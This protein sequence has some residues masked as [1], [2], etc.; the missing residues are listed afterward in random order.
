M[1]LVSKDTI[2]VGSLC[3]RANSDGTHDFAG[4]T[5]LQAPFR[6]GLFTWRKEDLS[7]R[8]ILEG[9]STLRWV[10]MQKF[11]SVWYPNVECLRRN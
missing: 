3:E 5:D 9:G 11:W 4:D 8:K 6:E 10:Y 1:S 7:T 2:S